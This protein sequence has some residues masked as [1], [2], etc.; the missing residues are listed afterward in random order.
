MNF[1]KT[2]TASIITGIL[3]LSTI[4]TM[5]PSTQAAGLFNLSSLVNVQWA[6]NGKPVVP[7]GEV[8]Q[9]Q[10]NVSYTTTRGAFGRLALA[11]YQGRQI[12]VNMEITSVPDWCTASLSTST[13]A[14]VV[15]ASPGAYIE[16]TTLLSLSVS[17]Q[18]PAFDLGSISIK[19]TAMKAGL[20]SGFTKEFSLTFTPGYKPLIKPTITTNTK[21]IGP[22]DTATFPIQIEN[23]GNARTIVTITVSNMP[24]DWNAIVTSPIILEEGSGSTNTAYLTIKPPKG[25]GYHYEEE[26]INILLTPAQYDNQSNKGEPIPLSFLVQSR[27]FSTPGFE[28]ILFLGALAAVLVLVKLKRK[29][30]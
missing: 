5:V 23:Q 3:F 21:E 22:L 29:K 19:A 17:D 11:A 14:F 26:T 18:A 1:P 2:V 12:T 16:Q 13:L 8:R 27:G 7:R 9:L 10:L 24:K 30:S 25:F 28:P 20:I 6:E 4:F 15:P